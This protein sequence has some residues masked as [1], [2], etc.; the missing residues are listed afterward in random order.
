MLSQTIFDIPG[1]FHLSLPIA[2][3]Y[4]IVSGRIE[5]VGIVPD[6]EVDAALALGA[7]LKVLD[8]QGS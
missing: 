5:G 2:D 1:G 4:S 6:I 3:Y 8:D 7:A